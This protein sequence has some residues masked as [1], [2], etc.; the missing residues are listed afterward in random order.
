MSIPR[1]TWSDRDK[2]IARAAYEMARERVFQRLVADFKKQAA[3]VTSPEDIWKIERD[4]R[5]Q[6]NSLGYLLD[7]RYS[8]LDLVFARLIGEGY[9]TEEELAGL[10]DSR[11]APIRSMLADRRAFAEE[12]LGA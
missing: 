9:L 4:L 12:R 11:M 2:K 8:Q 7:Y 3:A 1:E 5:E 10:S 6:R